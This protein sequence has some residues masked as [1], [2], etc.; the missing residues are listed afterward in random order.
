MLPTL[1]ILSLHLTVR[2]L[3][4]QTV[5]SLVL[6]I[7]HQLIPHRP[8]GSVFPCSSA[9]P[10]GRVE[11]DHSQ[12]VRFI[13]VLQAQELVCGA[14]FTRLFGHAFSDRSV[15]D[16]S[17]QQLCRFALTIW[18]KN[19]QTVRFVVL[20][21]LVQACNRLFGQGFNRPFGQSFN[22]PFDLDLLKPFSS[23]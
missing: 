18:C 9:S 11:L 19:A 20:D 12:T 3:R 22:K 14:V 6:Q 7:R 23:V 2:S 13:N 8:F 16:H 17:V 10:F 21:H 15:S 1:C 5:R 4:S